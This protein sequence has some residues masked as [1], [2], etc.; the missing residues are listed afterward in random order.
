MRVGLDARF[1]THPQLGGF[2]TYLQ[3]LVEGM[4][5][6]ETATRVVLYVDRP[7]PADLV[8]PGSCFEVR[9][10]QGS[11]HLVGLPWREQLLLPMALRRDGV[12]LLHAPCHTAP[13][14]PPVPMV[15]TVH[16]M[17]WR[18]PRHTVPRGPRRAALDRYYRSMTMRAIRTARVVVTVS[19]T[20]RRAICDELPFVDETSVVVASNAP[21]SC[22]RPVTDPERLAA[23]A[24]EF[25]L[26]SEFVLAQASADPRKNLATL[27]HAFARVPEPLRR[28]FPLVVVWAHTGLAP[29]A[30]AL[31]ETLAISDHV[32]FLH[33]VRDE[34]LAAL[35]SLATVFVFPS[36]AEGFGMPPLEAMACGTPVIVG[37]HPAVV[38]TTGDAACVV[39]TRSADALAGALERVLSD[40][41]FRRSLRARGA[42]RAQRFTWE[43]SARL[44]LHAYGMAANRRTLDKRSARSGQ[45]TAPTTSDR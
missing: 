29:S 20:S 31:C 19:Q 12:D 28:R 18:T 45:R 40:D 11:T 7:P 8:P 9:I 41:G 38:E 42:A 4:T 15:V 13:F 35:Y 2:K 27:I 1:L 22:F 5:R 36:L 14:W 33:A 30:R 3:G 17:F 24:A 21:R 32:R 25:E 44:T 37:D 23:V 43:E 26:P 16:D 10:L 39:N 6:V 34:T